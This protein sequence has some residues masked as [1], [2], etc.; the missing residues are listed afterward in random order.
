M[1][2]IHSWIGLDWIGIFRKL[3]GLDWIR[4]M[5]VTLCFSFRA[6][7]F[8]INIKYAMCL[9]YYHIAAQLI[10]FLTKLL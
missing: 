3:C 7:Y 4:R 8:D 9:I 10:R 1:R 2:W 6:Y 5:T